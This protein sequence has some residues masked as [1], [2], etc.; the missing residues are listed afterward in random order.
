LINVVEGFRVITKSLMHSFYIHCIITVQKSGEYKLTPIV[1]GQPILDA[2]FSLTVTA[3]ETNIDN[4][5]VDFPKRHVA[6]LPGIHISLFDDFGNLQKRKKDKVKAHLLPLSVLEVKA[7]D[8]GDGSYAV[9]YPP[10]VRGDVDVKI[11]VN[12][13]YVPTGQFSAEVQDNPVPEETQ[14]AVA[15][16][17]PSTGS[18]FN[19]LLRDVTP[20]DR[21]AIMEELLRIANGKRLPPVEHSVKPSK[22]PSLLPKVKKPKRDVRKGQMNPIKARAEMEEQANEARKEEPFEEIKAKPVKP[23]GGASILGG[24]GAQVAELQKNKYGGKTSHQKGETDE[25]EGK[26]IEKEELKAEAAPSRGAYKGPAMGFGNIDMTKV[27]LKKTKD[28]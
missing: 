12:G 1:E 7:R 25:Q 20:E 11:K 10:D 15:E 19:V 27:A 23:H 2:P 16:L 24:F 3:G 8:N 6:G 14:Q 13:K 22:E 5:T 28:N 4:T 18:L 21:E 9:D 26:G 17:L